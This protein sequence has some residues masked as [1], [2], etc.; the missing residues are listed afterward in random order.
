MLPDRLNFVCLSI[1]V[2]VGL[3]AKATAFAQQAT[4]QQPVIEQF[5]VDTAVSVPDRG[6]TSLGGVSRGASSS[7]SYGPLRLNRNYGSAF[8]GSTASAHVWI[9]DFDELDRQALQAAG[10]RQ[11]PRD[12][13]VRLDERADHAYRTLA[14][15]RGDERPAAVAKSG[16]AI[17][18]GTAS[19]P[20]ASSSAQ[21]AAGSGSLP[22]DELYRR[23]LK[24]EAEGKRGVALAFL[25]VA[26]DRGS[27]AAREKLER[28]EPSRK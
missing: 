9:Q 5:G 14:S 7:S 15:R 2:L 4:V 1:A 22:A 8:Q 10:S 16:A 21:P 18:N 23:G 19:R 26:R 3:S 6:R 27:N 28:L 11:R 24:A 12:E 25:R 17:A 20:I 13:S